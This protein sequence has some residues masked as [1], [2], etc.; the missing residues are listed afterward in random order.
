MGIKS[1][2]PTTSTR[3]FGQVS[4]FAEI[5]ATKPYK[6]LTIIKKKTAGRNS[7]G[8]ITAPH[9]GGGSKR[10]IRL[11]DFKRRKYGVKAKVLSIEYDPNR[12]TRIALIEYADKEKAYILAPDKLNVGDHV[13]SGENADIAVGNHLPL[14]KIPPGTPVHNIELRSGQGGVMV[15]A[16]GQVAQILTLE[17]DFAHIKLPS[18]EVRM[19]KTDCYATIGQCSNIEHNTI[20]LGKAGRNRWKGRRSRVRAV[21]MN[22]VDHPMGGGEGKSSGGR[23]PTSRTGQKAKG[24]KTRCRKKQSSKFIVKDRRKK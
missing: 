6:P 10:R 9:R 1:Y 19:F 14:G 11:V 12:S 24:L 2:K 17:N 23:H 13:V 16:A 4:D 20:S 15:R 3:R 8:H 5:T 22:P 7:Y 18:G 21:A